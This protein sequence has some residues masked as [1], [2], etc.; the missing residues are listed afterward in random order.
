MAT[1]TIAGNVLVL[2]GRFIYRDEN[3]AVTMVIRNLALADM[4]MGFYLIT[5]GVQDY[6]Y[7]N[8]YY[9]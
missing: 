7:R 8:E 4:L 1:L 5:I 6:R 3:V 2:W 9:K